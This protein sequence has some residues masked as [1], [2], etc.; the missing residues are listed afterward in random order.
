MSK[1]GFIGSRKLRKSS[2]TLSSAAD[3]S[4]PLGIFILSLIWAASLAVLILPQ[5]NPA[6]NILI[7]NQIAPQ[8]IFVDIDFIYKDEEATEKLKEN[9][10]TS[11]PLFYKIDS[12]TGKNAV[13]DAELMFG[14]IRSKVEGE[15]L[16][17]SYKPSGENKKINE[18]IGT[19]DKLTVNDIYQLSESSEYKD[20]FISLLKNAL[21]QGIINKAEKDGHTYGQQIRIIDTRG[22]IRYAK[23]MSE[24]TTSEEA[25][26]SIAKSLLKYYSNKNKEQLSSAMSEIILA[27]IGEKGN[28]L[29]DK[30]IT[31]GNRST[32]AA[33]VIPVMVEIKKRQPIIVKNQTVSEKDQRILQLYSEELQNVTAAENFWRKAVRCALICMFLMIVTGLYISHIHPEVTRSNQQIWTMGTVVILSLLLNYTCMRLFDIVSPELNISP[34]LQQQIIPLALPA[35]LLSVLIGLRVAVYAGLYVALITGMMF[36]DSLNILIKG[37][38]VCG[39]AGVAVRNAMNYRSYFIRAVISVTLSLLVLD[40]LNLW[41]F[42]GTGI[43]IWTEGMSLV[44]GMLTATMALVLLFVLESLFQISTNMTLL[45]I[46]DFNHPLLKRLQFEAP[47]TYHHS[48][49]VSTLAE[50]AAQLIKANPVK[51]RACA[52]YHDIGKLSKPDYFIENNISGESKHKELHPRIS[53][54]IIL[55]HVKEGVDLAIKYKLRRIVR[56]AIEQHHGTDL[57]YFF[58]KRAIEE[59]PDKTTLVQEQ[60]YRYPGPLPHEKEVVIISLADACEAASRTLQKPSPAKVDELVWEIFRKRLRDGQLDDG[61]LSFGEF[62]KVRKSFVTTL[63]TMLH[64]RIPYPKEEEEEEDENDLFMESWKTAQSSEKDADEQPPA[65]GSGPLP[66]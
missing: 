16:L 50:R 30:E 8:S 9:A 3:K 7:P 25:A 12:A 38:L 42:K 63:C 33:R 28:L 20:K 60:E 59:N 37:M 41:E 40:L 18:I 2:D 58:Y 17:S 65:S 48:L 57:V 21:E 43:L 56:D 54:M 47:G 52:L 22:R 27:L 39:F 46:C 66:S 26:Q 55:N 19:L 44:N 4:K 49:M 13:I 15:K 32:A 35:V 36:E 51:A 61:A 24:I 34:A 31:E 62:A 45:T 1:K 5:P 6:N 10:R 29:Y 23:L 14:E 64:S 53:S 11:V